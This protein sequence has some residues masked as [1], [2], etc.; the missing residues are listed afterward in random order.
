MDR[1]AHVYAVCSY[2][3]NFKWM[4]EFKT[5]GSKG[6]VVGGLFVCF[7]KSLSPQVDVDN[8]LHR[9]VCVYV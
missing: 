7:F 2:Q 1:N 4:D 5:L 6:G 3:I 9:C 8:M